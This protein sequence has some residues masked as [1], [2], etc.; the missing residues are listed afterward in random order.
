MINMLVIVLMTDF[1]VVFSA[2]VIKLEVQ[3]YKKR[4]TT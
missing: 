3:M 1:V 4:I 2:V